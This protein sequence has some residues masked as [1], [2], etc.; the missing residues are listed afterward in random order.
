MFQ[1]PLQAKGAVCSGLLVVFL[2]GQW[3]QYKGNGAAEIALTLNGRKRNLKRS[4]FDCLARS[5]KIPEKSTEYT[6][7]RF[8]KR[9]PATLQFIAVS[10]LPADRKEQYKDWMQELG[11]KMVYP[12]DYTYH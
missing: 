2:T 1:T 10:F 12:V 6:Y 5:L 7:H 3:Y 8:A 9:M 4:D 11:I